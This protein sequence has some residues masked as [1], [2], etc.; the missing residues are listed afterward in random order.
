MSDHDRDRQDENPT[1][2]GRGAPPQR[3]AESERATADPFGRAYPE[4]RTGGR[5]RNR[6]SEAA[7]VADTPP[8]LL[9]GCRGLND[10]ADTE[11]RSDRRPD[12]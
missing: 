5:A 12:R 7:A 10:D 4:R 6:I 3:E 2:A 9:G 11:T 8:G 1:G